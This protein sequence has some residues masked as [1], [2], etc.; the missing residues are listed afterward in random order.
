VK[1]T[2]HGEIVVS[3]GTVE[4]DE[5]KSCL[6]FSVR[7]TGIGIP[8]DKQQ[9]IFDAFTQADGSSTRKYGGTGLGLSI[10]SQLV[11]MMKGS[12]CLESEPGRGSTFGFTANFMLPHPAEF[13][14]ST[15]QLNGMPVLIVDDNTTLLATLEELLGR[16]GAKVVTA[17]HPAAAL[18]E[19]QRAHEAGMPYSMLLLD[20]E[21]PEMSGLR[22]AQDMRAEATFP[23]AIIMLLTSSGDLTDA[24]CW[25]DL[26]IEERVI[27]PIYAPE[28]QEAIVRSLGGGGRPREAEDRI[29]KAF[30]QKNSIN[31][32][33]ILLVEDTPVN[34]KLARRLL[35]KRGHSVTTANNGREAMEILEQRQGHFD[36]VLMDVQMPE[37]DGYQTTKAIRQRESAWGMRLPIVAMTAHALER[38]QERCLAAG[39]DA[40][41]SKPIQIDKLFELI[42]RIAVQQTTVQ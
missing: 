5:K 12:F 19:V 32:L 4:Q 35:E 26:G 10:S 15:L 1:F 13:P 42:E 36:L 9:S 40:Y 34:Q 28:L 11:A 2:E 21:M 16:W 30:P 8:S 22:L 38:D 7:D 18:A 20:A 27:K 17:L 29:V 25:R 24:A 39:M 37:M 3:V 14:E 23:G 41:L 31:P 6:K 33:D